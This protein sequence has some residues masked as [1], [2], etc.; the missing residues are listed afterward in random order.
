[1][2][3]CLYVCIHDVVRNCAG[4]IAELHRLTAAIGKINT[5][6]DRDNPPQPEAVGSSGG[7]RA[8]GGTGGGGRHDFPED[9]EEDDS[10]GEP[11]QVA[12]VA[13]LLSAG[14]HVASS[15]PNAVET[16]G[17][18]MGG[19]GLSGF[20]L[21]RYAIVCRSLLIC[22]GTLLASIFDSSLT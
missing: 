2:Y 19:V 5:G 15:P 21:L 4:V 14:R 6:E 12:A 7:G 13:P 9:P 10:D 20:A 17:G 8:A 11:Q 16:V 3:V 1:M 22:S 18:L